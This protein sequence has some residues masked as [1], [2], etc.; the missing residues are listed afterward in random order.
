MLVR[1]LLGIIPLVLGVVTLL[2]VV[3]HATPGDPLDTLSPPGASPELQERLRST[4]GLDRPLGEQYVRWVSAAARGDFGVSYTY[5][6]PV[7]SVIGQVLP[8]TLLLSG[9]AILLSFLGGVV[10][11]VFQAARAGSWWD[12]SLSGVTLALYSI[13]SFC[14]AVLLVLLFSYLPAG[15]WGWPVAF[16]PSGMM[17]SGAAPDGTLGVIWDRLVHL[18]L[19]TAT[20]V[21]ILGSGVARF[22]RA[23]A[24]DALEGTWVQ[25]ARAR[26]LPERTVIWKHVVPNALLPILALLG[27]QLPLLLGGAVFVEVVFAWPGMGKLMVDAIFLRDYPLI[28]G[29]TFLFAILVMLGNLVADLLVAAAD[30]RVRLE[31][32]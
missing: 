6:R 22:A 29:G 23:S 1:R 24:L 30:P 14:L 9:L 15:L 31:E 12:R 20:L 18:A 19:P 21:L 2:F 5:R 32:R 4:L 25:A 13:P 8:N 26:G 16:P 17:S 28:L 27:L 10:L 3:V 7:L 11:G